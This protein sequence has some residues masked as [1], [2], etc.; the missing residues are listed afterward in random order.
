MLLA[1]ALAWTTFAFGGIY[2]HTLVVPALV[3]F[4]LFAAYHPAIL[5]SG[6]APRLDRVVLAVIGCVIVQTL[7]LPG[8]LARALSP[9][10]QPT[11]AA[12]SLV[13]PAG[14]QPLTI[15]LQDTAAALALFVAAVAAFLTARQIFAEG[16][17]RTV[18]RSIAAIGLLLSVIAIAQD[19]TSRGLMYWRWKPIDEAAYPFG[20]FV[21]RNHFGTWAVLAVPICIGY[22]TAHAA[23]HRGP[24]ADATWQTRLLAALDGRGA[25]ILAAGTL[26]ILATVLSLSRSSMAGL[27]AAL[28]VGGL[29][30]RQRITESSLG[31]MRPAV[32]VGA[33]GVLSA[34]AVWFGVDAGALS[35][36]FTA[37]GVGV[38]DRLLI[39]RD[40]MSVLR[41]FWLTGTG[42]GTFQLSMTVYQRSSPGV[43]YN[44]A[45]NHYLQVAAEGGV[46]LAV[47]VALA[48]AAFARATADSLR[49]D[50]SGMFWVRAG[51]ASGLAGIAVQSIWET[52][53][54][55]PAN[56]LLAAIAGAMVV[57]QPSHRGRTH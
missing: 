52:G 45:H 17:V 39:W 44:Q 35:G 1:G 42:A 15:D 48:L 33:L 11:V 20:P 49:S 36:R 24:K 53:L 51:A 13:P 5:A 29:F 27:A 31:T 40:T 46:L 37:A 56:A 57:H 14:A 6:P 4:G 41:D 22:L 34:I 3:L 55:T 18:A 43:I 10:V 23:A 16:G 25:L 38:A 30:A 47:P 21:N 50:R 54:T 28:A 26:L 7:P 32:L 8:V 2:P 12:I 9:A 19:A